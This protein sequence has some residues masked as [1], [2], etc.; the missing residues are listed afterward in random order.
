MTEAHVSLFLEDEEIIIG[1]VLQSDDNSY[2]YTIGIGAKHALF[3]RNIDVMEKMR[4]ELNALIEEYE[5][6]NE[7]K[8]E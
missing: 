5:N 6:K 2:I 4:D 1:N 3:L 7:N 8:G